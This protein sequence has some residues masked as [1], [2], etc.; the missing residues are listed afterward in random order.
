[1]PPLKEITGD[2]MRVPRQIDQTILSLHESSLSHRDAAVDDELR[3]FEE[4]ISPAG[5]VDKMHE[6]DKMSMG[7]HNLPPVAPSRF[8]KVEPA[9]VE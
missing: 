6:Q 8:G 2:M 3:K 5:S 7:K 9:S 1:M 4:E